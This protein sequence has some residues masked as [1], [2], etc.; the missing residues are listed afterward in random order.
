MKLAL[1]LG[2][3]FSTVLCTVLSTGLLG[4]MPTVGA[5][6]SAERPGRGD[7]GLVVRTKG[8]PKDCQREV[9]GIVTVRAERKADLLP[10]LRQKARALGG[11]RVVDI[12]YSSEGG[13]AQLSGMAARCS[14]L[15][16][17]RDFI[18]LRTISVAAP[19]GAH[20]QALAAMAAKAEA[21]NATLVV[22]LDYERA[23]ADGLLRLSG[24]AAR[25][26]PYGWGHGIR[27]APVIAGR[28]G[29]RSV[30]QA[31]QAARAGCPLHRSDGQQRRQ[32][33]KER[34][35]AASGRQL[36]A[37]FLTVF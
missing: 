21:M 32:S 36:R 20:R 11:D 34:S 24:K 13:V 3:L 12:E 2:A 19:A 4:C 16:A 30:T 5:R 7:T 23:G 14:E 27:P 35:R 17:G 26:V 31:S 37:S 10:A 6:Y 28:R 9:L 25:Y 29:R 1:T 15:L 33:R 8:S 18:V 22:A